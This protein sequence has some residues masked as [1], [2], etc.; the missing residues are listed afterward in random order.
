M[1]SDVGGGGGGGSECSESPIFIFF[2]RENWICAMSGDHTEPNI[3]MTLKLS[4]N[5]IIALF[6]S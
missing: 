6:V 5:D 4:F 1:L 2:I 3:D